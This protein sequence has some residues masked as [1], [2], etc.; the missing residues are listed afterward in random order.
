MDRLF[1]CIHNGEIEIFDNTR[2]ELVHQIRSQ[3]GWGICD[4]KIALM[5]S[6]YNVDDAIKL[7]SVNIYRIS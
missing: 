2:I 7:L 3:K 1:E 5:K 6:N 4:I